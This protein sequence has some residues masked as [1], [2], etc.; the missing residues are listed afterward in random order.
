MK[1]KPLIQKGREFINSIK[2]AIPKHCS[3]CGTQYTDSDLSLIQKDEFAAILHLT[4]K[5]CKES[6]L[7]NVVS[8]LGSLQGSSRVPLKIDILSS[9]EAKKFIGKSAIKSDDILDLHE[10]LSKVETGEDL[11]K[12]LS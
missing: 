3:N 1:N 10:I 2:N 7:I 12:I 9:E 8:P 4:C 11:K 6:Y 5:K